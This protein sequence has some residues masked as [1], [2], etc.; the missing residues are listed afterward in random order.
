MKVYAL[1]GGIASGKSTASALFEDEGIPVIDADRVAH[2]AI[3][4]GGAAETDVIEV[5]GNDILTDGKID[6]AKLGAVVFRDPDALRRLNGLVH[7]AVR[8]EIAQRIAAHAQAGQDSVIVEAALHAE[9]GE[10]PPG[11][12]GLILVTCPHEERVRRLMQDRGMDREEAERRIAAQTPPEE[13]RKLARWV[14]DNSGTR[15]DL[16]RQVTAV[17]GELKHGQ[18]TSQVPGL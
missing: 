12:E 3:G 13:K 11:M 8:Q 14:I 16:K 17:A 5:F 10:L 1:T 2:E 18:N 4:P 15:S 9:N 7:P 6:R